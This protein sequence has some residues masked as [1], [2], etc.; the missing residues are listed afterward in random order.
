MKQY[1]VLTDSS[2]K[3]VYGIAIKEDGTYRAFGAHGRANEWASWINGQ[4]VKSLDGHLP[5][6]IAISQ[7][8]A[9][10][11]TDDNFIA[12]LLDSAISGGIKQMGAKSYIES[13]VTNAPS[14]T[15][16]VRD[17]HLGAFPLDVRQRAVNFK[18]S[19]FSYDRKAQSFS[20][21]L[22]TG[23]AALDI[24]TGLV[25][26]RIEGVDSNELQAR[27][28][29]SMPRIMQR[30]VGLE[31]FAVKSASLEDEISI[32]R[33]GGKLGSRIG[34]GLRAAPSGMVFVDITGAIDADTDG[35]VFEGKPGL[36]RPI[37]PRFTL[38]EALGRRISS[39]IQGD[40]E[41][42]EKLR[43]A[44]TFNEAD[45]VAKLRN[46]LG[47][48]SSRISE[49]DA[50]SAIPRPKVPT[51]RSMARRAIM[52]NRGVRSS[53]SSSGDSVELSPR[54]VQQMDES[55]RKAWNIQYRLNELLDSMNKPGNRNDV[56]LRQL[57]SE[58]ERDYNDAIASL[59]RA[60][61]GN[62]GL[63][64]Y[65]S[66]LADRSANDSNPR[67]ARFHSEIQRIMDTD[68][69]SPRSSRPTRASE[70]VRLSGARSRR[71]YDHWNETED[72]I[73]WE[74]EG[75]F[76]SNRDPWVANDDDLPDSYDPEDEDW[77][78][79]PVSQRSSRRIPPGANP[80]TE[81][82]DTINWDSP[83]SAAD[84]DSYMSWDA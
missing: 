7:P 31:T 82:K 57:Y 20:A 50:T 65:R 77:E 24:K 34:R 14:T 59:V 53:R 41:A 51:D 11:S 18:T 69:A 2:D 76:P 55:I 5:I 60:A 9:L 54:Q 43:R 49:V 40:A 73:W 58:N 30:R 62:E 36:E 8:R 78:S 32:K 15:P 26:S 19:A 33:I 6:D 13:Y 74:E 17:Y 84:D 72:Q 22:R 37:I 12:G 63:T 80:F 10:V 81:A 64:A 67:N 25:Q 3:S 42:N 52:Q 56:R 66:L 1:F 35:I 27:L 48:D 61:G 70:S 4:S 29:A 28:D 83:D 23:R 39:A 44:G 68:V 75:R 71:D 45:S 16:T 21:L 47:S 46:L 79:T 38:P